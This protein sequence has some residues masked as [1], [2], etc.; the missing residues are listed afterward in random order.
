MAG[1]ISKQ[2]KILFLVHFFVSII[3]GLVFLLFVES[4]TA[5]IQWP[6]V[7]PVA[8]RLLG[9]SVLGYST[10][11]LLAWR[12]TEWMKVKLIVQ[13]EIVW[14]AIG[15]IV[16]LVCVFNPI[17]ALPFFTWVFIVLL[18][19]FVIVFVWFYFQQEKG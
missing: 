16:L 4:F 5:L 12:E 13:I 11:S 6:N 3:I 9:A 14:C 1:Q 17:F 19:F 15:A 10:S 18:L 2:L 7:D 8:G